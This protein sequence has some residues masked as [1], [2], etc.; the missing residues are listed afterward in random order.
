M[1]SGSLSAKLGTRTSS[2]RASWSRAYRT[3]RIGW[4]VEPAGHSRDSRSRRPRSNVSA[5]ISPAARRAASRESSATTSP[6]VIA[7]ADG[8][9]GGGGRRRGGPARRRD[10]DRRHRRAR[11]LQLELV[12]RLEQRLPERRRLAQHA[13]GARWRRP[14]I[15]IRRSPYP[16]SRP[17]N[18]SVRTAS[19]IRSSEM[20]LARLLTI[21]SA[22][23]SRRVVS[24]YSSPWNASR[25][26]ATASA[27]NTASD[28]R[29]PAEDL[30]HRR[31]AVD[32]RAH[33][34]QQRGDEQGEDRPRRPA[35][36]DQPVL[37]ATAHHA[38]ARGQLRVGVA[39]GRAVG[40]VTPAGGPARTPRGCARR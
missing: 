39:H 38:F 26:H 4:T 25:P 33:V 31:A 36:D 14:A 40:S 34:E 11:P 32:D 5:S 21:P 37:A 35:D 17:R 10:P 23:M 2:G 15:R 8:G 24:T 28:E 13:A 20:S 7:G 30:E 16:S 29:D 6:W 12:P 18:G 3:G 22:W 19:V 9:G 1:S 27:P